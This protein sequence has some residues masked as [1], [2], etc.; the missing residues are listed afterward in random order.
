MWEN[1]TTSTCYP[2]SYHV[3]ARNFSSLEVA[4]SIFNTE[5]RMKIID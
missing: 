5:S 1:K 3:E 4:T 2:S